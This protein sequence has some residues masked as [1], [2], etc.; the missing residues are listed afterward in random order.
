MMSL[1]DEWVEKGI[2]DL[3]TAKLILDSEKEFYDQVCFLCQQSIEKLL[4]AYLVKHNKGISKTHDLM[5]LTMDCVEINPG[6]AS[7]QKAAISLTTYAVDF[8]YPGESA[9]KEESLDSFALAEKYSKFILT[10]LKTN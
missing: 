5:K 4:K 3:D 2:K 9:S 10:E 8:R 7:W 1:Y 6:F